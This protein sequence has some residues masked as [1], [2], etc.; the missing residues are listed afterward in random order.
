MTLKFVDR[1]LETTT[2]SGTGTINLA[3][4][5]TNFRSFS[6]A[7]NAAKVGYLIDDGS[8]WEIGSGTVTVGSPN[9]LSRTTVF[10]STNS[11]ALVNFSSN[12]KNVRL[13]PIASV[14]VNRDESLNFTDLLGVSGGTANAHTVTMPVASLAYSDG[15][16]Y[17][18]KAPATNSSTTVTVN[19]D[20]RGAKNIKI[21]G[22]D[23]AVGQIT[24]ASLLVGVYNNAT[25]FVDIINSLGSAF[26]PLAGGNMTGGINENIT[27]VA[28]ATTPNIWAS[29]GNVIDYTGTTTAT[30]FATAPQAGARR[31]LICAGAS[32]FTAG[33]NM[34][35]NGVSSGNNYTAAAG[36]QI[37]VT[38][39]TTTQ[40]RLSIIRADGTPVTGSGLTTTSRVHVQDQKTSG[41]GGGNNTV[42]FN[43]RTLNTVVANTVAGA[44]LASNQVTLP[45]G[46]YYVKARVPAYST[47]NTKVRLQNITDSTT[48]ILGASGYVSNSMGTQTDMWIIGTLTIASSKAFEV[49]HYGSN[50]QTGGFGQAASQGTEIY[51]EIEFFKVA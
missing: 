33:A 22:S 15:A 28:S 3:G 23:P 25:G 5:V 36:D 50:A 8:S 32:V 14:A 30:G 35:I 47:N 31:T 11:N 9:T 43:T 2:T 39:V 1:V 20:G 4:P 18:W 45:A 24:N 13:V 34:L 29:T 49:Q 16:I 37:T 42:A 10:A 46:T 44:S 7:G 27:T 17:M 19:V 48:A 6:V 26:L 21:N 41:T 51:A 12:T 38:A 40:F